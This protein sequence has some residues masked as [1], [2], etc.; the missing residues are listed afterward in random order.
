VNLKCNSSDLAMSDNKSPEVLQAQKNPD[1]AGDT[2][3][4]RNDGKVWRCKKTR[5]Q[6]NRFCESHVKSVNGGA[7]KTQK[8]RHST[9]DIHATP[10]PST[11]PPEKK[12]RT[13]AVDSDDTG[14]EDASRS[15]RKRTPKFQHA[16]APT[17]DGLFAHRRKTI[18]GEMTLGEGKEK[19]MH[20]NGK[21]VNGKSKATEREEE[22][23]GKSRMCHQCQRSDKDRVVFCTNCNSKRYCAPCIKA[24]YVVT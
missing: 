12:P 13:S 21:E 9:S 23:I 3:C 11:A 15:L 7:S 4:T 6:G 5:V 24:W 8:R 14:G 20:L 2:R 17:K 19:F 18:S 22:R 16:D 10:R 1:L